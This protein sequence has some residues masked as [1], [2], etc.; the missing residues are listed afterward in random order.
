ME[1]RI[2]ATDDHGLAQ[3]RVRVDD[4][5]VAYVEP[6]GPAQKSAELRIPW[7]PADD[8]LKLRI[9]A[10]DNDGMKE[11]YAGSL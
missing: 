3:V 2:S 4:N 10:I 5:T 11:L 1:V 6:S 8:V 7:K 9:E